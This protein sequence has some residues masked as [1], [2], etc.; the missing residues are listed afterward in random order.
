M[1]GR[2]ALSPKT[3]SVE[4][5]M[6]NTGIKLN[7]NSFN[8]CPTTD[9]E[10]ITRLRRHNNLTSNKNNYNIGKFYWGLNISQGNNNINLFNAR[11]ESLF[12][13]NIYHTL[14]THNRILIPATAYYEWQKVNSKVK[15]PYCFSLKHEELFAF[16]GLFRSRQ[17]DNEI[18]NEVTIITCPANQLVSSIH[19]RMPVILDSS[20]AIHYLNEENHINE[21]LH[22]YPDELMQFYQVSNFVNSPKNNTEE[23]LL[24]HQSTTLDFG[25]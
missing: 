18:I 5:L 19:H 4:K 16:A 8:I 20:K 9:I 25:F 15:I 3:N 21:F 11:S 12:T 6:P 22:S 24:P 14:I 2:F 23:C 17:I 13:K 7:S 10:G 1:C